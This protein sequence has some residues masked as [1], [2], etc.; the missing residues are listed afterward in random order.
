MSKLEDN[1]S[2]AESW[3]CTALCSPHQPASGVCT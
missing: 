3:S 1:K 2:F